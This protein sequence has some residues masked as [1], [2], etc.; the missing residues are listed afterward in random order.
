MKKIIFSVLC[1]DGEWREFESD[2]YDEEKRH[3]TMKGWIDYH[4]RDCWRSGI[5]IQDGNEF[6][7]YTSS[8]IIKIKAVIEEQK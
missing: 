5:L 8:D 2:D 7:L 4:I 6:T 1:T 3:G